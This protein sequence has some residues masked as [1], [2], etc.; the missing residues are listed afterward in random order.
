MSDTSDIDRLE[1]VFP[2]LTDLDESQ[3]T[4]SLQTLLN[5]VER[6]AVGWRPSPG[7]KVGGILRDIEDSESGEFGSYPIL[8]I[9]TPSGRLVSVHGFHTVLRN[10][11][12]RK[13]KRGTL[14]PGDEVA[15]LYRGQEGEKTGTRDV[16]HMYNMVV[17]RPDRRA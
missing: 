2:G 3:A 17:N 10:L 14:R 6:Q 16:P 13:Y 15:I 11:I 7:D 5:R 1:E 9:E 8:I 12:E 4:E